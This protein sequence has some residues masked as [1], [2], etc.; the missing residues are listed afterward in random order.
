MNPITHALLGWAVAETRSDLGMRERG[1]IVAAAVAPDLDGLGFVAESSL[2]LFS[3][4]HHVL[5]H[6]LFA[7]LL[8]AL[9]AAA[10]A[11]T[12]RVW[13]ALLAFVAFHTH[14]LG[15]LAGGRGP[16]DYQWPILYFYPWRDDVQLVWSGQWYLNAWPNFAIT[17]ALLAMTFVLAWR[18]GYSIVGLVSKRADAAFVG[19]LKRRYT[20]P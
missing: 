12:R 3:K 1:L 11:R 8:F 15:D 5:A 4:Y 7:G 20:S 9:L 6:N 18:R 2:F 17:I 16:D 10:L 14:I 19:T 13:T